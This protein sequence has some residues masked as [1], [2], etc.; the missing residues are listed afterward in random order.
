MKVT[1]PKCETEDVQRLAMIYQHGTATRRASVA[2]LALAACWTSPAE[3]HR[4]VVACTYEMG[5]AQDRG[6]GCL[7]L[8]FGWKEDEAIT[9][10]YA[11]AYDMRAKAGLMPT[12]PPGDMTP[13]TGPAPARPAPAGT[14]WC[15]R[16][17]DTTWTTCPN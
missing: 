13:T 16:I 8:R 14:H 3:R 15:Q 7:M 5:S 2:V 10:A 4:Q 12:A 11:H 1:C 6:V 17:G 9:A